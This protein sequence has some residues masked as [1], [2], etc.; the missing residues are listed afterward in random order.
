MTGL[1]GIGRGLFGL[2]TG[3]GLTEAAAQAGNTMDVGW[4]D[5][6]VDVSGINPDK[7]ADQLEEY[8]TEK[9]GDEALGWMAKMGLLLG[10]I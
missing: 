3:E 10:G 9:T 8:V 5:G 2:A 7:G 1:Q 4:K 6:R